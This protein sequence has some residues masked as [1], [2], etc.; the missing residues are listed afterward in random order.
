MEDTGAGMGV[1]LVRLQELTARRISTS[2]T[3]GSAAGERISTQERFQRDAPEPVRALY[4]KHAMG[5][6]LFRNRGEEAFENKTT[7]DG[8]GMGRWSWSSDAWD[9]D[10]DGF[11]DLYIANGMVSGPPA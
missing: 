5:N 1:V 8:G 6:S 7:F 3:C 2:P 9:F 11:S 4:R 10:H